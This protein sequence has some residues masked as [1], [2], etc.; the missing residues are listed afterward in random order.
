MS[1]TCARRSASESEAAAWNGSLPWR[2]IAGRAAISEQQ[3]LRGEHR[4]PVALAVEPARDD[5]RLGG[6]IGRAQAHLAAALGP[7]H[8]REGRPRVLAGRHEAALGEHDGRHVDLHVG[9]FEPGARAPERRRLPR[10]SRSAARGRR[11]GAARRWPRSRRSSATRCSCARSR[12]RARGRTGSPRRRAGP[13][14]R[15]APAR[16]GARP[17]RCPDSIS[18]CGVLYAPAQSTT[19]RSARSACATPSRTISAPVARSP[20]N[21]SRVAQRPRHEREVRPAPA[22]GAGRRPPPSSAS[23]R[24]A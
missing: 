19:S 24:A 22:P 8:A 16:A 18:S 17:G 21:S 12:R 20:S 2:A 5:A 1:R 6:R 23:R 15:R 3:A 13:A 4:R 14:A 7:Q 11:S 9:R 10:C